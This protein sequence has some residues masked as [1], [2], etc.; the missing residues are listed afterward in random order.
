MQLS[1]RLFL[2]TFFIRFF[3]YSQFYLGAFSGYNLGTR[4]NTGIFTE[5]SLQDFW[6]GGIK[7]SYTYNVPY[8]KKGD[9]RPT[10]KHNGYENEITEHF[11][12]TRDRFQ[13][14]SFSLEYKQ[15]MGDSYRDE[16]GPYFRSIIGLSFS[17]VNR[18]WSVFQD[19]FLVNNFNLFQIKQTSLNLGAALGYDLQVFDRFFIY[20]DLTAMLPFIKLNSNSK[21]YDGFP[22]FS[23]GLQLG[24]KYK[25]LHT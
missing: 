12:S 18:E 24:I 14:H 4:L 13:H 11:A 16:G 1:F 23:I 17:K 2:A 6:P 8:S 21:E 20:G 22:E 10:M 7:V 3:S 19:P 15:Y 9:E 5:Y 25:I